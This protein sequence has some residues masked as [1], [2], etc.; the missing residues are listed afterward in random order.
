MRKEG[1]MPLELGVWRIDQDLTRINVSSL[2]QEERLEEFLDKDIIIASP[3]WMV[4]GRQVHTDYGKYIDLL[5]I[6]R[7]GNLIVL[8]LKKKKTPREIVAQLLDY[9]SWVNELK[10]DD[11]AGIYENYNKKYHPEN[12]SISLDEA[13]CKHFKIQEM[14]EELNETHQLV[15]VASKLDESTERIVT[16]LAKE[17]SVP[18]NAV[19]FRVFKD[20]EREYLSSMWFIDPTTPSPVVSGEDKEPWNGEFYVSFGHDQRRHWPDAVKYAF[21]SAGGGRWYSKTLSRLETGNRVWVN[22]PSKGYVGVGE[23]META[24]KVDE[25]YVNTEDGKKQITNLPVSAPNMFEDKEDEELAE[26]LVRV[27]WLKTVDIDNAI[28]EKGFF[29]NQNTVCTPITKKWQ[30]TVKRLKERFGIE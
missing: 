28:K 29:G 3:Y 9:A 17:H 16:Y 5:A 22:V 6:D 4:V 20:E 30:H 19:F 8:E 15:I 18:I 1:K 10:D 12:I 26:Y 13:F 21:I 14:P 2:D 23:V 25:F 27:K 11:I 24:V 7:D